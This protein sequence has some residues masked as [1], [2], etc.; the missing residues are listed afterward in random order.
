MKV[1]LTGATGF[2][3]SHLVSRLVKRGDQLTALV[4]PA[5]DASGLESLGVKVVRG[6]VRDQPAVELAV[7]DCQIVYHLARSKPKRRSVTCCP[8][9]G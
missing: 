1:M 5:T 4:R 8:A 9:F 7:A 2:I 6:D 3:G